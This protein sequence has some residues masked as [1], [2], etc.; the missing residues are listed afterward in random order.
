MAETQTGKWF[1]KRQSSLTGRESAE[2][3]VP[4]LLLLGVAVA[5]VHRFFD[6]GLG[7]PG[8]HGL[9]L[10]TALMFARLA[11]D[12]PWAAVFV[13]AGA[14]GGDLGLSAHLLHSLKNAPL[15][16]L[17]GL[18]V[19]GGFLLLG[20]YSRLLPVAALLGGVAFLVKP[21]AMLGIAGIG[22]VVFGFMRHGVVFPL[23]THASFGVVGAVVGALLARAW[24][25]KSSSKT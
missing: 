6:F 5:A 10:L 13:A 14:A 19:D 7:L 21:L 24:N 25:H 8:H 15:Y 9:E 2:L 1:P 22:D 23:I 12:R 11:S 16:F 3:S 4:V 17:T 20:R 18:I